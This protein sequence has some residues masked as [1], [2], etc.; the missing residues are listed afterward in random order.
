MLDQILVG[1]GKRKESEK[2]RKQKKEEER[3]S[4]RLHLHFRIHGDWAFGIHRSKKKI[5]STQ[6]ELRVGSII[7]GF[8]QTMKGRG[9]SPTWFSLGLRA[10]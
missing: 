7:W 3:R 2:E 8:R 5:S 9:F 1:R 6:R 4:E 10:I